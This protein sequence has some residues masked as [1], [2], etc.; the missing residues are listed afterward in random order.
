MHQSIA[1]TGQVSYRFIRN[2]RVGIAAVLF[3]LPFAFGGCGIPTS[4][5]V[6][7]VPSSK[8]LQETVIRS[9]GLLVRDRIALIDISGVLMNAR[10]DGLFSEGEHPVSLTVEQ[11][12]KAAH[13]PRVKAIVLRINSPGGGVTASDTLYQEVRKFREKTGKPVVAYFQDVAASGAYFLACASDEIIAQRTS[14]TGSI[15][16][17]MLMTNLKGTLDYIGVRT[18]AITS[19][20]MKDAGSPFRTMSAEE[21]QLFQKMVNDFYA[22]F[23]DAVDAGRPDL[24]RQQVLTIADGRVYTANQALEVGLIDR[25]GTMDEAIEAARVRAGCDKINV[26]RYHRPM[27]WTPN[28][29]AGTPASPAQTTVNLLNIN[30]STSLWTRHPRFMY[31]W[32]IQ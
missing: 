4:F 20:P 7:A 24:T 18:D 5:R 22:Q 29:Y 8:A 1:D 23:V 32:N 14:V 9:G 11:L 25:I 19:G 10:I 26:V 30:N 27:E 2:R 3:A 16:V 6:T 28:V 17:I 31:I 21:R 15:G 13:D 12:D